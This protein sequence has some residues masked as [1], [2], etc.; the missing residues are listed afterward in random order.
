[1]WSH[2][3]YNPSMALQIFLLCG[4]TSAVQGSCYWWVRAHRSH[5]RYVDTDSDP[6]NA[7]RG[8]LWTH[9]GWMIFKSNLRSGPS[10]ISDLKKDPLIQFQ[11]RY[12]FCLFPIFGFILPTIIPGIWFN[13][14]LGGLYFSAA[15]RLTIAHHVSIPTPNSLIVYTELIFCRARFVSTPL[16][17]G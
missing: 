15:L 4:G 3:S 6:Y 8:L 13:D 7:S 1:M 10:D 5:H 9:I 11:H 16:H 2:R 12:Y 17:T 14:W